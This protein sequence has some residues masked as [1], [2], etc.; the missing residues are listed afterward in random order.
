MALVDPACPV[1]STE[2]RAAVGLRRAFLGSMLFL[3]LGCGKS[4]TT[5]PK[6]AGLIIETQQLIPDG[7][8]CRLKVT[9]KNRVGS[10][11]SGEIVYSLVDARGAAIGTTIVFPIVP[12]NE[13][14]SATSDLLLAAT[15]GHRLAC[16]EIVSLQIDP[17]LSTV[18]LASG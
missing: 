13:T 15:D 8:G 11:I 14:K 3:A 2:G 1:R 17:T 18:P 10:D 5:G 9:L 7:G 6:A 16:S 4:S 12:D